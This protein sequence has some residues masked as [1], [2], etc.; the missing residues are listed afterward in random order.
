MQ[1]ISYF[2]SIITCEE[3]NRWKRD[4]YQT[5]PGRSHLILL[6]SLHTADHYIRHIK[7]CDS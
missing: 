5:V 3:Y 2:V 6:G 4:T 7:G 1:I